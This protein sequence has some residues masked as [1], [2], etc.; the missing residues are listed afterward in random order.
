MVGC[1]IQTYF[2]HR[3]ATFYTG[4]TLDTKSILPEGLNI[5]KECHTNT[6]G[7]SAYGCMSI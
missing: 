4:G 7:Q 6:C 1:G 3:I 2:L 5:I